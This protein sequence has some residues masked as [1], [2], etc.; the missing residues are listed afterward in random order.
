MDLLENP[1]RAPGWVYEDPVVLASQGQV[2]RLIV[3]GIEAAA[4]QRADLATTLQQP[5]TFLDVG[6][7]AGWLAMEVGSSGYGHWASRASKRSH[8][9]RRFCLCSPGGRVGWGKSS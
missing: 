1:E 8:P 4:T 7:G 6:T 9:C 2:S 5:G 3:R